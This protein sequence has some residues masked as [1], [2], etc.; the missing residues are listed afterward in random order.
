MIQYDQAGGQM[1]RR[2][3]KRD[4]TAADHMALHDLDKLEN[5]LANI[6][7][8]YR[9]MVAQAGDHEALRW[10]ELAREHFEAACLFLER[11]AKRPGSGIGRNPQAR[12]TEQAS[13]QARY[14][15]PPQPEPDVAED[16]ETTQVEAEA[17]LDRL[18]R[19]AFGRGDREMTGQEREYLEREDRKAKFKEQVNEKIN[20]LEKRV[21]REYGGD[22]LTD[23]SKDVSDVSDVSDGFTQDYIKQKPNDPGKKGFGPV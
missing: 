20:A 15:V 19:K 6:L 11:A 3:G 9:G 22:A 13:Y 21:A 23:L 5:S 1:R 8:K 17:E 4:L 10:C 18:K 7:D 2:I 12:M 16:R 14:N